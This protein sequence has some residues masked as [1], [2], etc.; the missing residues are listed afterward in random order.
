MR[1][2]FRMTS[3]GTTPMLHLPARSPAVA[4]SLPPPV[5]S[6][7]AAPQVKANPH[8]LTSTKHQAFMAP[9]VK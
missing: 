3:D 1:L 6:E 4:F 9:A 8:A 7:L 2:Y 5:L